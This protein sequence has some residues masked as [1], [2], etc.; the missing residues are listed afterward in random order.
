MVCIIA[1]RPPP[2][3]VSRPPPDSVSN[4]RL[5][6]I[7]ES[8]GLFSSI[9]PRKDYCCCRKGQ[10]FE[11]PR[12]ICNFLIIRERL[13]AAVDDHID[14]SVTRC[15][16]TNDEPYTLFMCRRVGWG[17]GLDIRV[18]SWPWEA[19]ISKWRCMGSPATIDKLAWQPVVEDHRE[20]YVVHRR[21]D[22]VSS[23]VP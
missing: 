22:S 2:S 17:C 8:V 11:S 14:L 12:D 15:V 20:S 1:P 13:H 18:P 9:R 19:C 7:E 23:V 6:I 3:F 5:K 4:R 21:D 16:G 10:P